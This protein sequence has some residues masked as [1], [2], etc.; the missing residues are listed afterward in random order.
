MTIPTV[1]ILS[2]GD[3]GQAIA[4]VLSQP[5]LRTLAALDNRS[6]RTRQLAAVA[7]IQDVGSLKNLFKPLIKPGNSTWRSN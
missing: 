2:P 4:V 5:G 3:M 1:G 6:D 7:Q